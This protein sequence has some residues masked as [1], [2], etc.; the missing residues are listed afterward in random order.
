MIF[1]F[2]ILLLIA[3]IKDE[4]HDQHNQ[5]SEYFD[6]YQYYIITFTQQKLDTKFTFYN[7]LLYLVK[8][9]IILNIRIIIQLSL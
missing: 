1:I 7:L 8:V 5:N 3:H 6:I 9:I 2:L 4:S